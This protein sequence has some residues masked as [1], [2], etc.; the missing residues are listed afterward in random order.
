MALGVL[1][2]FGLLLCFVLSL[3]PTHTYWTLCL[4][5]RLIS[6]SFLCCLDQTLA[7]L[8]VFADSAL[9]SR[10]DPLKRVSNFPFYNFCL[11]SP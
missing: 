10:S 6:L 4:Q 9:P 3:F 1:I 7:D 8:L 11:I 2:G 5:A